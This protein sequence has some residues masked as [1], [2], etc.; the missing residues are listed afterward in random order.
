MNVPSNSS[1]GYK[2]LYFEHIGVEEQVTEMEEEISILKSD[3]V[4]LKSIALSNKKNFEKMSILYESS[5]KQLKSLE[6]TL[7][8]ISN[9]LREVKEKYEVALTFTDIGKMQE[10]V[11]ELDNRKRKATS[12]LAKEGD[13]PKRKRKATVKK[14]VD[15]PDDKSDD[16]GSCPST[17]ACK[18]CDKNDP[19]HWGYNEKGEYVYMS[20][21]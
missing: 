10:E 4:E 20:D 12:I 16:E 11:K 21:E 3:N 15:A 6:T 19:D 5:Q 2:R 9:E 14:V 1:E 13:T 17:C 18:H 7:N 8:N